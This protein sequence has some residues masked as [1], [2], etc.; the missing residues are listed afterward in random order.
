LTTGELHLAL[1]HADN[2]VSQTTY[3]AD[4]ALQRAYARAI[5]SEVNY[6]LGR[7]QAC[8]DDAAACL[9]TLAAFTP[10]QVHGLAL[11]ATARLVDTMVDQDD[12]DGA[13]RLITDTL[14]E[15]SVPANPL[16]AWLLTSRGR[17]RQAQGR[18]HAAAADFLKAGKQLNAW[19]IVNPAV[20]PWRSLGSVSYA[21]TGQHR[22]ARTWVNKELILAREWGSAPVLGMALRAAGKVAKGNAGIRLLREAVAVLAP[23]GALLELTRAQADLGIALRSANRLTEAR[24]HLRQVAS[25]AQQSGAYA[26]ARL[27]RAELTA[28]GAPLR[29]R[30]PGIGSLTPTERRVASMAARG[31]SNR[32][33]SE[34]LFVV[35]RTVEIHLTNTYRK[36]GIQGR[37]DLPE[38]IHNDSIG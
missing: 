18:N 27:A 19:R 26:L 11:V 16:G 32:Q 15:G 29:D 37:E 28:T 25:S 35:Q 2:L 9:H 38:A 17:L 5:R 22:Q 13:E 30:T 36:L 8:H 4:S 20:L 6:Q 1:H 10:R 7:L 3:R 21:A 14:R 34:R 31:L 12:L 24:Q 33:I 23:C